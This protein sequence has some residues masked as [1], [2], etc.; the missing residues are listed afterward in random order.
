MER[1]VVSTLKSF[2]KMFFFSHWTST[3]LEIWVVNSD[4]SIQYI[5]NRKRLAEVHSPQTNPFAYSCIFT[6]HSLYKT[7]TLLVF[8]YIQDSLFCFFMLNVAVN[9]GSFYCLPRLNQYKAADKVSCSR[10]H[11]NDS[12]SQK[13]QTWNPSI[14]KPSSN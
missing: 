11:H 14:P 13:P 3:N 8:A 12:N 1:I 6:F 9:V 7:K 5:K 4:S 10:T 2:A